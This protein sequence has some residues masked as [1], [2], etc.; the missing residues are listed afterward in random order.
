MWLFIVIVIITWLF[1]VV[2]FIFLPYNYGS[3]ILWV[4]RLYINNTYR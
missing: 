2:I 4:Y 3:F 1:I